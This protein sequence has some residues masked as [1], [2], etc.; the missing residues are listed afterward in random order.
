[1]KIRAVELDDFRAIDDV[2]TAAFGRADE[3]ELVR[4]LRISDSILELVAIE[5]RVL[6]HIM[7]SR[8]WI[9]SEGA[10]YPAAQLA[11]L[12]ITPDRQRSGIGGALMAEGFQLLK[13]A[14]ETHVF[15]LGHADY[16]PRHGFSADSAQAFQS[17][18]PRPS[19]MLAR[20]APGGP[21]SGALIVPAAF[22]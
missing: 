5:E 18:W 17:P 3:A 22:L 4:T 6:G 9:E 20:I 1:M 12:A 11:P 13:R 8:V 16:Y 7:Y 2:V 10:K 21:E 19:F 15:V 14:G